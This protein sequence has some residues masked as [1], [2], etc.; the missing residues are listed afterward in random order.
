MAKSYLKQLM[1]PSAPLSNN[2][3]EDSIIDALVDKLET[4]LMTPEEIAIK[5]GNE[6][7][8]LYYISQGDCVVNVVNEKGEE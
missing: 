8:Y 5:Q 1:R 6:G 7:E 2:S 3:E 4:L